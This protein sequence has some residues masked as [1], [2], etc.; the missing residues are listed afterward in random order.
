MYKKYGRYADAITLISGAT[1]TII[2]GGYNLDDLFEKFTFVVNYAG[3]SPT[4]VVISLDGS[5]DQTNWVSLG[6]TT[7]VSTTAVGF[8]SVNRCVSYIRG[9]ITACTIGACT[10]ITCKCVASV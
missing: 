8:A 5:I 2:G 7:D 4:A 1:T 9:N 3:A 6:N 10:G